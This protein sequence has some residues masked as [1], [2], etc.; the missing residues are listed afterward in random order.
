MRVVQSVL[1]G[2][3]SAPRLTML[4]VLLLGL[5]TAFN[6][7]LVLG[8]RLLDGTAPVAPGDGPDSAAATSTAVR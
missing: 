6:S 1:G 7:G 8:W 3:L 4:L 5:G 2:A